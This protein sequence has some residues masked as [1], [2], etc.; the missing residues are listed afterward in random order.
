[1]QVCSIARFSVRMSEIKKNVSIRSMAELQRDWILIMN[2]LEDIRE[3]RT[4]MSKSVYET[5]LN[6]SRS[7]LSYFK[8]AYPEPKTQDFQQYPVSSAEQYDDWETN[9]PLNIVSRKSY[10]VGLISPYPNSTPENQSYNHRI[11]LTTYLQY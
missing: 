9:L 4:T 7:T 5:K 3:L 2:L 11:S 1:M 8:R 10:S 6:S